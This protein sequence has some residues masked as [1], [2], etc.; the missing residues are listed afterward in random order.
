M[1]AFLIGEHH[2]RLLALFCS[3]IYTYTPMA[4]P[5]TTSGGAVPVRQFYRSNGH[6]SSLVW[7]QPPTSGEDFPVR[8]VYKRHFSMAPSEATRGRGRGRGRVYGGHRS[9]LVWRRGCTATEQSA[10]GAVKDLKGA[11]AGTGKMISTHQSRARARAVPATATP[12]ARPSP[13]SH[14]SAPTSYFASNPTT[15]LK[16][17]HSSGSGCSPFNIFFS[18]FLCI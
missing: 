10:S 12:Y 13:I 4:P 3:L 17:E 11:K 14:C 18:L 1:F 9:S 16:L 5:Q 8:R 7:S 6:R 15:G 2:S